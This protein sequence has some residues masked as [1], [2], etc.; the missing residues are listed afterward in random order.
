MPVIRSGAEIYDS[1]IIRTGADHPKK[2]SKK[3]SKPKDNSKEEEKLD[4]TPSEEEEKPDQESPAEAEKVESD[5]AEEDSMMDDIQVPEA[6][7]KWSTRTK[8]DLMKETLVGLTEY[9]K[10]NSKLD[11]PDNSHKADLIKIIQDNSL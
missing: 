7:Q 8:D 1:S 5:S 4:Q 6:P 2:K 10:D 9:V 11:I 3:A